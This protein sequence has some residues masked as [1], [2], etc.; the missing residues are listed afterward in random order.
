MLLLVVAASMRLE[1]LTPS[2]IIITSRTQPMNPRRSSFFSDAFVCL[3][4]EDRPIC[5]GAT[6][7]S[8]TNDCH[9][10]LPK[11]YIT[12][13]VHVSTFCSSWTA[14]NRPTER[15]REMERAIASGWWSGGITCMYEKPWFILDSGLFYIKLNQNRP[16]A[17][18][19]ARGA[20]LITRS[21]LINTK[22]HWLINYFHS[23]W[24]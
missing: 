23:C 2:G 21:K 4:I 11:V 16:R 8:L 10:Y 18:V 19:V 7:H 1:T 12:S 20:K 17:S 15:E 22:R 9:K 3:A 6:I 13:R 5:S 24:C 14:P